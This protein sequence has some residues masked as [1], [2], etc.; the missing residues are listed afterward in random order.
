[1]GARAV[2]SNPVLTKLS[3]LKTLGME[4]SWQLIT[5]HRFNRLGKS[6]TP[7]PLLSVW[8]LVVRKVWNQ[9]SKMLSGFWLNISEIIKYV[10]TL[11]MYLSGVFIRPSSDGSY[12]G[13]VMSVRPSVRVSVRQSLSFPHFSPSCFDVLRWNLA[14][15]FLVMNIRSSSSVVNFRQVL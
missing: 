11:Y 2:G 13:M 15:H 3:V 7:H 12:Y 6:K 5:A 9:L 10:C 4:L 14:C 8:Y 1:M